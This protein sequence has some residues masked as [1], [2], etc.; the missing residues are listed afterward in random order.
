MRTFELITLGAKLGKAGAAAAAAHDTAVPDG[1]MLHGVWV[2]E[3]GALNRV[4][5]LRSREGAPTGQEDVSGPVSLDIF[6]CASL[7]DSAVV[8]LY[9][10]FPDAPLLP[11][12]AW[13]PYYEIRSY[14]L[15]ENGLEPTLAAWR[16]ALPARC[17]ISP[18]AVALHTRHGPARI[19]HIW[20]YASLDERLRLREESVRR[21]AWP[22]PGGPAWLEPDMHSTVCL[23]AA[24][25]P[26]H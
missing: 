1:H 15:K 11:P 20:P 16:Q 4:H 25:S 10:P 21:G 12:G 2:S 6:G 24:G 9:D 5:V 19:T 8:D 26:W 7:L 22:P 18:L 23:P 13:G 14:A 17:E 3:I